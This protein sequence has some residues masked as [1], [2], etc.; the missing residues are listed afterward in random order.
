MTETATRPLPT[1]LNL[2]REHWMPA[3]PESSVSAALAAIRRIDAL[4][5]ANV[6]ELGERDETDRTLV[7][8]LVDAAIAGE[9]LDQHVARSRPARRP[10]RADRP[11]RAAAQCTHCLRRSTYPRRALRSRLPRMEGR[12]RSARRR[13]AALLPAHREARGSFR[14]PR[15]VRSS[16]LRQACPELVTPAPR[17]TAGSNV[18]SGGSTGSPPA[19]SSAARGA[20]GPSPTAC[21]G[22]SITSTTTATTPTR[23]R[24]TS[25]VTVPPA[26]RSVASGKCNVL[27]R[28]L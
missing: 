3:E 5:A 20:D 8:Q 7:I 1:D 9:E 14:R 10:P 22:I 2:L 25:A 26:D 13:V 4:I 11:P 12:V 27:V 23:G 17:R 24:A 19:T 18:A 16:P 15:A 6:A 21:A 28:A